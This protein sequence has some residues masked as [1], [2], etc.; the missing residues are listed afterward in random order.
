MI[1]YPFARRVFTRMN[2]DLTKSI[3][4]ILLT[5]FFW[6]LFYQLNIILFHKAFL[7]PLISW[8]FLPAGIKIVAV[9]VLGELGVLG[10]FLGA[11]ATYYLNHLNAGN[12]FILAAVSAISPFIALYLSKFL[13]K[14]DSL[15]SNLNAIHLLFISFVYAVVNSSAHR[16]YMGLYMRNLVGFENDQFAMFFGDLSGVLLTLLAMSFG[17]KYLRYSYQRST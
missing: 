9:I 6:I 2:N 5:A 12:P 7:S 1:A 14:L 8:L 10:L 15:Y 11:I 16:L 3:G 4:F 13:L 17:I